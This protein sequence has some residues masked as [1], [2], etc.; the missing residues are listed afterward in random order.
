MNGFLFMRYLVIGGID[1]ILAYHCVLPYAVTVYVGVATV[2]GY[3]WWFMFLEEGPQ[4]SFAA[5]VQCPL[6][7]IIVSANAP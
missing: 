2:L 3:A 4:V 7:L 1:R 6:R 5:L